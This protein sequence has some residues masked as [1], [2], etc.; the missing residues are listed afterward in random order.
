M[1]HLDADEIEAVSY[2]DIIDYN[3]NRQ[4][5]NLFKY[6]AKLIPEIAVAYLDSDYISSDGVVLDPF[7]GSGTVMVEAQRLG[8][9]SIGIDINPLSTLISKVKTTS[10]DWTEIRKKIN[11]FQDEVKKLKPIIPEFTNRDYWFNNNVLDSLGKI[12]TWVSQIEDPEVNN[13]FSFNFAS[14]IRKICNADP[15]IFPPTISKRMKKRS[16]E[17]DKKC[18]FLE[19]LNKTNHSLSVLEKHFNKLELIP[20]VQCIL[21]SATDSLL[22]KNSIDLIITSP[23]YINAQKYIRTTKLEL[24]WLEWITD[25]TIAELDTQ[26]I[27][28]ERVYSKDFSEDDIKGRFWED[29][30]RNLLLVDRWRAQIV[31]DYFIRM[32]QSIELFSSYLK[33]NCYFVLII[34]NNIIRGQKIPNN[35]ILHHFAEKYNFT[36]LKDRSNKDKIK[37]RS[38]P[39]QRNKTAGVMDYEYIMVYQKT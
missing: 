5:H 7:C 37:Q 38:L 35:M 13:F 19:F 28:T 4:I 6:P 31:H 25:N 18:V 24:F 15:S 12:K 33:K 26:I 32:E 8:Y 16:I 10:L 36:Y 2:R 14:I 22:P 1:N 29:D 20:S 21:G 23:P 17:R 3:S 11:Q 39:A 30:I 34:G 27:G 9:D